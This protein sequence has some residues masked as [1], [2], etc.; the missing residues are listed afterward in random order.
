MNN[1][2]LDAL[3]LRVEIA[4]SEANEQVQKEQENNIIKSGNM[5]LTK[6]DA[7]NSSLMAY[8]ENT[9]LVDALMD[10]KKAVEIAKKQYE[11]I[12][13]QTSIAK[14]MGKVVNEKTNADIETAHLKVKDQQV[15]NK[16]KR[17]EQRNKLIQ[18]NA[19][20]KFLEREAKHKLT[21]QKFKQIKEKNYDLLLRYFR[22][23][24][25]DDENKWVYDSD[26]NGNPI[27]HMPSRFSLCLVRFFD[28]LTTTLNQTA[29]A[30]GGLNKVVF[31]SGIIILILAILFIPPLRQWL[32]SL[33]GI[34]IG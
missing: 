3:K 15:D 16:I 22:A 11:D 19:E 4:K 20:K 18:L 27:I 26:N 1:E 34:K 10:T 17:A 7:Q 28:G 30:V 6:S 33:I 31:K 9:E 14:K 24:H 5:P 25:K 32:L 29:D 12:N 23:K 2:E 8:N 21:M 13:N